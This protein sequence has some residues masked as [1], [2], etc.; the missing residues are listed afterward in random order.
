M[1]IF[2]S[3]GSGLRLA[4][5]FL[6]LLQVF[7]MG[8]MCPPSWVAKN[9]IVQPPSPPPGS[10]LEKKMK[11]EPLRPSQVGGKWG[12]IN[13]TGTFLIPPQFD[14][15]EPFSDGL[16][17]VVVKSRFGYIA[18]DGHFV[19]EPKYFSA[20]DFHEGFAWVMTRKPRFPLGHGEYCVALFAKMTF[21]DKSGREILR[22]FDARLVKNF[23]EGLA[24]LATSHGFGYI[25]TKGEWAI[26]PQFAE[27]G[28]F[29]EGLAAVT[30]QR[31]QQDAK[32]KHPKFTYPGGGYIDKNGTLAI[33]F[34]Y[35]GGTDFRSGHACVKE[36]PYDNDRMHWK[37]IDS[38]GNATPDQHRDEC[39]TMDFS[40]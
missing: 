32:V 38:Y 2:F 25:S 5:L 26:K 6:L 27:A 34:Q 22:P 1:A 29:S 16:A 39:K 15:A 7:G 35:Y 36:T 20:R 40:Y 23:S 19:I 4:V 10:E 17:I 28:N 3:G 31:L 24:A 21:I 14:C 30:R 12:Y 37:V 18:T 13:P 9:Q 33:P 8:Q 11:S